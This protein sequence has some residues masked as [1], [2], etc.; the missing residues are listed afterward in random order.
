MDK[1]ADAE[2]QDGDSCSG[3]YQCSKNIPKGCPARQITYQSDC[4]AKNCDALVELLLIPVFLQVEGTLFSQ[5][6]S[7]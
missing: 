3:S 1:A 5:E 6:I 2:T 4:K 7:G